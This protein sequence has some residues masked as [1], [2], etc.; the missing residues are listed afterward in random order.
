[1]SRKRVL[2]VSDDPR[3]FENP[4]NAFQSRGADVFTAMSDTEA[5]S[6]IDAHGADLIIHHGV[7]AS[8]SSTDFGRVITEGRSLILVVAA[9]A[10]TRGFGKLER[11]H[12]IMEPVEGRALLR[13]SHN[14]LG[15]ADRKYISIL[16]QVRVTEPKVTTIF[17]KSRDLSDGGI[18]VETHQS[19]VIHDMVVVSF[20]IPGADRMIQSEALVM[21]EV[22]RAGGG[23][24]YGL[25]FHNLPEADREIIAEFVG[26]KPT[27]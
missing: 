23:R 13:L 5:V 20:L 19:L 6:F 4:E 2:L 1:M 16:V 25:K 9:D 12:V 15:V 24:R 17:G 14:E 8:V 18:L 7:P 11:V 21:R 26:A 10:N 27:E 3:F 22:V